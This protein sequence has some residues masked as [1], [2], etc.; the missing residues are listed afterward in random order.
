MSPL[1]KLRELGQSFWLDGLSRDMLGD[2]SLA[3]R[4]QG[5][6][7]A[8]ALASPETLCRTALESPLYAEPIARGARA[9][10]PAQEIYRDLA[11]GD[12]VAACDLLLPVFAASGRVDGLACL[13]VSP[14]LAHDPV[15]TLRQATLL[16]QL[17]ARP[18]LLIQVAG[19]REGIAAAEELLTRGIG[20]AIA[21]LFALERYWDAFHAYLRAQERRLARGDPLTTLACVAS[22]CLAPIDRAVDLL[23]R[24]RIDAEVGLK[25]RRHAE[26]LLGRTAV[27]H[28]KLAYASFRALLA[29]ERWLKLEGEGAAPQRLLWSGTAGGEPGAPDLRYVEPLI[30]PLT[31]CALS[32][33]TADAFAET[34]RVAPS[35]ELGRDEARAVLEG[36]R[37]L[38][39]DLGSVTAALAD[40]GIQQPIEAYD[41][42]L[43]WLGGRLPGGQATAA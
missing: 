34:G 32:A 25:L 14:H 41:R 1:L 28:A 40:G 20:V 26:A 39:I 30:G 33:A 21:P 8:G 6:G 19:T 29:S 38:G 27:A 3:R 24:Q 7:L 43:A 17:A 36:L 31:V 9:G 35:V 15:G 11:V 22:L 2:G 16:W 5:Q 37:Q 18:N 23:L 42:L 12:A 13:A 4:L 10:R